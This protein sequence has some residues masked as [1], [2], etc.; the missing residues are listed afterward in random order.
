M[1]ERD[2]RGG[3]AHDS[4]KGIRGR[5]GAIIL[6]GLT[7]AR[8]AVGEAPAPSPARA[9]ARKILLEAARAAAAIQDEALKAPS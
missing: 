2:P 5:V 4:M 6:T 3:A 7:A 9:E 8:P 1:K